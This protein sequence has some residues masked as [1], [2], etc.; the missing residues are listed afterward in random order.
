M[1]DERTCENCKQFTMPEGFAVGV[2]IS[3]KAEPLYVSPGYCCKLFEPRN[4]KVKPR[5]LCDFCERHKLIDD[6]YSR[7]KIGCVKLIPLPAINLT[8]GEKSDLKRNV[9][10]SM[11]VYESDADSGEVGSFPVKFCPYCGR[12]LDGDGEK[13]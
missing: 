11:F 8:T 9:E 6:E 12:K 7:Y 4:N 10:Y 5:R 13:P 2:C 1:S 3:Y